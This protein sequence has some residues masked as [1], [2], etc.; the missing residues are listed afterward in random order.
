MQKN[1]LGYQIEQDAKVKEY[2][3]HGDIRPFF[4]LTHFYMIIIYHFTKDS[5]FFQSFYSQ[6][7]LFY[8]GVLII[9]MTTLNYFAKS[10]DPPGY[11][12]D[13]ADVE[14]ID[15]KNIDNDRF[16]CKHCKI[17]VPIRTSHC[18]ICKKC[19]IRRDHHCPYTNCCVGR[20]NH[21]VF[22]IFTFL[23]FFS[24][25][26]PCLDLSYNFT[27]YLFVDKNKHYGFFVI[28]SYIQTIAASTF[29]TVKTYKMLE[30]CLSVIIKNKTTW[31]RVKGSHITYLKDYPFGYSPF[32]K[33]IIANLKEFFTMKEKKMKWEIKPANLSLFSNE[34]QKLTENNGELFD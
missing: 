7:H 13:E 10:C 12:T 20:D 19:V 15:E 25:S 23:E 3:A 34:L 18:A 2:K 26:V 30:Q 27:R 29:G 6:Y 14:K 32:D 4:I 9:Y 28:L 33:G 21:V 11:A 24:Q 22:F 31:E 8:Y 1:L 5:F 16:Y 17:Y